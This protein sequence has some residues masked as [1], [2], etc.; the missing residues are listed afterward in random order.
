MILK[1]V[2]VRLCYKEQFGDVNAPLKYKTPEGYKLGKWQNQQR[3]LFES[4]ELEPYKIERLEEIGFRWDDVF[5]EGF[6]ATLLYNKQFGNVNAPLKYK[7]P[8]GYKLG[9]WQNQQ[10]RLFESDEL[11]PYKI[12]RLE[13]IGFRLDDAFEEGFNATL[14]YKEQIGDVNAPLKYKTPEGYKLGKWQYAQMEAYK[15]GTLAPNKINRLEKIGFIWD[16]DD[17]A[18]EKGILASLKYKKEF[19]YVNVDFEYKTLDGF[20]LKQWQERQ[21]IAYKNGDLTNYEIQRLK[22]IGFRWSVKGGSLSGM[23]EGEV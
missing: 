1:K 20:N 16:P 7:T 3:R 9:K 8:E 14:L 21:R 4:G 19:G 22:E 10:R 23:D 12:K 15:E 13:E 5:E 11:E 6:N 17:V 2:F 18:F